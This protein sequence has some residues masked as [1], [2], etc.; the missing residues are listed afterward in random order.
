MYFIYNT[1]TF[2]YLDNSR[3]AGLQ[4]GWSRA[5]VQRWWISACIRTFTNAENCGSSGMFSVWAFVWFYCAC[6]HIHI[7]MADIAGRKWCVCV[8][9]YMWVCGCRFLL[10][11]CKSC[12]TYN[13]NIVYWPLCCLCTIHIVLSH[14][15]W[16]QQKQHLY[17]RTHLSIRF[18]FK[19]TCMGRGCSPRQGSNYCCLI[20]GKRVYHRNCQLDEAAQLLQSFV[21]A[22]NLIELNCQS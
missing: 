21:I 6:L 11:Y 15:W 19:N 18:L 12:S 10:M 7:R 16:G 2:C 3:F 1:V 17:T 22:Q 8:C 13:I 9:A 4:D 14:C 20:P 5:A